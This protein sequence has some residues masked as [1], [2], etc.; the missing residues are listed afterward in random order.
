MAQ[1][2]TPEQYDILRGHGTEGPGTCALQLREAGRHVLLRRLW[3]GVVRIEEE[4]R[5]RHRLAELQR[6]GRGRGR[7]HVRP[8]LRHG[9]HR[10]AL[11]P[12]RQP[13]RPRVRG[14]PAA[15]ASALLHQRRCH[16]LQAGVMGRGP[17][18]TATGA[19]CASSTR[20]G[21]IRHAFGRRR[22]PS[23]VVIPGRQRSRK[24]RSLRKLGCGEARNPYSQL[25]IM[26][27][28]SSLAPSG[29]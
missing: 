8:Q 13:S 1:A 10:G 14:R 9:P 15:D 26:E 2:P 28:G 11:Q 4:V 16:E 25:V 6:S 20:Y 21:V 19:L 5:E 27:S 3:A 7:D 12:L 29:L 17:A 24:L 22:Y 23:V 18:R